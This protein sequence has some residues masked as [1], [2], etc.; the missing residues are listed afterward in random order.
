MI[1]TLNQPVLAP[2]PAPADQQNLI[3]LGLWEF[4]TQRQGDKE[5][6]L[7][8]EERTQ[9]QMP[10]HLS[11]SEL[12]ALLPAGRTRAWRMAAMSLWCRAA[13]AVA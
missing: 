2:A 8:N 13:A 1:G 9:R 3:D 7:V 6:E 4:C 11:T 10:A 12:L 5:F